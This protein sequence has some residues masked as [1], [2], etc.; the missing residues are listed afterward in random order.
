L[1]AAKHDGKV[2][3]RNSAQN[4]GLTWLRDR[5]AIRNSGD[6]PRHRRF[7]LLAHARLRLPCV[8]RFHNAVSS[9]FK[10]AE[11]GDIG[12]LWVTRLR[13]GVM[14]QAQFSCGERLNSVDFSEF[15]RP[16]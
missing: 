14:N 9:G 8:E 13:A 1:F 12:L 3:L 4:S 11:R 7:G 6:S 15:G 16:K 2:R 10:A 5:A